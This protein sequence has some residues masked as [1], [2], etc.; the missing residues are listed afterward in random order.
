M[1]L[2]QDRL[3]AEQRR[4]PGLGARHR[5]GT[6]AREG[7]LVGRRRRREPGEALAADLGAAGTEAVFL[8]ADMADG[9][10][11]ACVTAAPRLSAGW[12]EPGQRGT[13]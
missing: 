9:L 10:Q 4:H 1:T 6:A 12:T 8:Q 3:G 2:L 11:P 5:A 13:G 7:A